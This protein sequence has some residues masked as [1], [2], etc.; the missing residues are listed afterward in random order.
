MELRVAASNESGARSQLTHIAALAEEQQFFE[1]YDKP[2]MEPYPHR[3]DARQGDGGD[4][5]ANLGDDDTAGRVSLHGSPSRPRFDDDAASTSW[6]GP[7]SYWRAHRA[8][9]YVLTIEKDGFATDRAYRYQVAEARRNGDAFP[10]AACLSI[11]QAPCGVRREPARMAFVPGGDY[12]LVSWSG[13][14]IA[15]SR[16]ATSSWTG[17]RSAIAS[18]RLR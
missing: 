4:L 18:T 1:A 8:G 6:S 17:T 14:P 15:A 16:S 13:R 5:T 9:D 11:D 12:R 3:P 10:A 7:R 2:R